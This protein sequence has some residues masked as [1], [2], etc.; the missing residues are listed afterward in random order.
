MPTSSFAT[1]RFSPTNAMAR[2][3]MSLVVPIDSG[4]PNCTKVPLKYDESE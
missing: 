1:Q 2:I 3:P 4:D